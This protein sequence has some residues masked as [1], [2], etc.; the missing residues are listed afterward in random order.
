MIRN[1]TAC[2]LL[3]VKKRDV[4]IIIVYELHTGMFANSMHTFAAS[5]DFSGLKSTGFLYER[6]ERPLLK[7]CSPYCF[8]G[9]SKLSAANMASI[10]RHV[11]R[12]N[13]RGLGKK[14]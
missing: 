2:F 12:V 13:T 3:T 10:D 8:Q 5:R 11:F 14:L 9:D 4:H 1:A 7:Q 6:A